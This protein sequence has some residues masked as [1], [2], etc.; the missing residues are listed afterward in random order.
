MRCRVYSLYKRPNPPSRKG[1]C[2]TS[3]VT[4]S[5]TGMATISA[6]QA[7]KWLSWFWPKTDTSKEGKVAEDV[8]RPGSSTHQE[9]QPNALSVLH[10]WESGKKLKL[11]HLLVGKPFLHEGIVSDGHSQTSLLLGS[12]AFPSLSSNGVHVRGLDG[13]TI[14]DCGRPLNGGGRAG[15]ESCMRTQIMQSWHE[16]VSLLASFSLADLVVQTIFV[17]C[18]RRA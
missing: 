8:V 2:T 7:L 6:R 14:P 3:V 17:I 5:G 18:R 11:G 1:N 13:R 16:G 4:P 15:R 10:C 9:E 12:F